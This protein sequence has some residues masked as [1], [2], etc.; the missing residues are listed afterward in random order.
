[1]S[2]KK[3][4]QKKVTE[5]QTLVKAAGIN[6][7]AALTGVVTAQTKIINTFGQIQESLI[8]KH[9]DL[10]AIEEAISLK[11]SELETLHGKDQALLTL[12]EIRVQHAQFVAQR[13]EE[14]KVLQ[15]QYDRTKADL[16]EMHRREVA[17]FV[18]HRNLERKQ[19]EDNWQAAVEDRRRVEDRRQKD[20]EQQIA[21]RLAE[22]TVR[23]IAAKAAL[24]KEL[25]FD[26]RVDAEVKK[27]VAINTATST[28]NHEVAVHTTNIQHAAALSNLTK[29]VEHLQRTLTAKDVEIHELKVSLAKAVEAQ[30]TLA[31]AAVDAASNTKAQADAMALMTNIGGGNGTRART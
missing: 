23:E 8:V 19:D 24:D 20:V 27:Q 12:D 16:A 15:A 17:D 26:A 14:R 11:A 4:V 7:D 1:M 13:D 3:A 5:T 30:T 10:A 28:R 21:D 9:G 22:L 2:T 31:R 25:T 18:Y 6:I 29:D